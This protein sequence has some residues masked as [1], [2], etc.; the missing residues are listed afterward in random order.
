VLFSDPR[1]GR[2]LMHDSPYTYF[3]DSDLHLGEIS[4]ECS[5]AGASAAA[6]WLTLQLLPLTPDGL[7]AILAGSRRAAVRWAE[8]IDNSAGL[9]LYQ[10]PELDIVTYFPAVPVQTLSAVDTATDRLLRDG[11]AAAQDPVY[12]SVLRTDADAFLRRHPETARDAGS[13]RVLRSALIKPEAE[14]YLD[15]L[16][17]RVEELAAD[18]AAPVGQT[19]FW[20]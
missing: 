13:A 19:G 3:T 6:F 12:L 16:H 2:H 15:Q 4:L 20:W 7:G 5:R 8:L 18:A 1:A 9:R 14:G 10:K 17:N 11:M